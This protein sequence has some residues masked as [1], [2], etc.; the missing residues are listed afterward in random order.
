MWFTLFLLLFSHGR[1]PVVSRTLTIPEFA[2]TP[3]LT[4]ML[5]FYWI[6]F[7]YLSRFCINI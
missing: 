5:I 4:D 7:E 1:F 3:V 2:L 6:R